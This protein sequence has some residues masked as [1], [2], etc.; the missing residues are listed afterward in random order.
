MMRFNLLARTTVRLMAAVMVLVS[1]PIGYAQAGMVTTDQI[2]DAA[3]VAQTREKVVEFLAREDVRQ[4]MEALGVD[5]DDA[6]A[7]AASMTDAEVMQIAGQLDQLPAGQDALGAI[8]GAALVV[9]VILLITDIL[10]LTNIFPFV[11]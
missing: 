11:R 5:P 10:G 4:Q 6:S 3:A 2:L 1:M 9:F 8:L 7:R